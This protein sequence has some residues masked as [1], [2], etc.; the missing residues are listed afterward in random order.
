MP[1]LQT[2]ISETVKNVWLRKFYNGREHIGD[3]I[4]RPIFIIS[5]IPY[6]LKVY[7]FYD[8]K[9]QIWNKS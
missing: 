6:S 5:I 3:K 1:V 8:F 4:C 2:D 9:S 7:E